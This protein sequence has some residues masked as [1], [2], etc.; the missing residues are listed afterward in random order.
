MESK[1]IDKI[2]RKLVPRLDPAF[3]I[4]FG[5]YAKGCQRKESDI[6]VAFYSDGETP[7]KYEIFMLAQELAEELKIEVD[8]INLREASTVFKAQIFTTGKVIF[9]QNEDTRIKEQMIALSMYAKLNEERH[10][11]LDGISKRG[12]IYEE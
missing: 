8:L 5:S 7:D 2:N 6:D 11:I 12:T 10:E 3:I 1:L 9:S 4:V